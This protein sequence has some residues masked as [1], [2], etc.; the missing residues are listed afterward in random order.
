MLM[1]LLAVDVSWV[2][3]GEMMLRYAGTLPKKSFH[4]IA[5]LR[6]PVQFNQRICLSNLKFIA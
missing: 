2:R 6:H 5:L 3:F 4:Y 1:Y